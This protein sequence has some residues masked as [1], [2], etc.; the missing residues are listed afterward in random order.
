MLEL[1]G[2]LVA[3]LAVFAY[4]GTLVGGG[5]WPSHSGYQTFEGRPR[6]VSG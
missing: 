5:T 2:G 4:D 1:S 3:N 6:A